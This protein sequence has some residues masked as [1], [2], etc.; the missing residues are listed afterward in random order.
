[1]K[2]SR[3]QAHWKDGV[4]PS[5]YG[6]DR[7]EPTERER[8]HVSRTGRA[9]IRLGHSRV[10]LSRVSNRDWRLHLYLYQREPSIKEGEFVHPRFH[11]AVRFRQHGHE[12]NW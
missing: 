6:E 3:I 10:C 4:D 9:R 5:N 1:M 8:S 7:I 2:T 12:K 11:T